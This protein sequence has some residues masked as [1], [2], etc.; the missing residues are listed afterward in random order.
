MKYRYISATIL[1][2]CSLGLLGSSNWLTDS[3]LATE[4]A[5]T[6]LDYQPRVVLQTPIRP[7]VDP[8]IVAGSEA[9]ISDNE[10]VIGVTVDGASRAYPINQLTGPSR[11]IINDMIG[12]TAIAATW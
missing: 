3:S 7:I 1:A 5:Q 2:G 9:D 6:E 8:R 12:N 4:S 11:E 10:L